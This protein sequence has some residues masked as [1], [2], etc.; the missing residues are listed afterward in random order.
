MS[1]QLEAAPTGANQQQRIQRVVVGLE[2]LQTVDTPILFGVRESFAKNVQWW[3]LG[4]VATGDLPRD[5]TVLVFHHAK[6]PKIK[7]TGDR[8]IP[9][10]YTHYFRY[11]SK[12]DSL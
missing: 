12:P 9:P 5:S 7:V 3:D 10:P 2:F 8:N 1:W 6:L 4:M 11:L